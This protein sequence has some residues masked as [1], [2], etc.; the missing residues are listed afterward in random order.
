[1]LCLKNWNNPFRFVRD[2][3]L[4]NYVFWLFSS[5]YL[6]RAFDYNINVIISSFFGSA[7]I[8]T[9]MIKETKETRTTNRLANLAR[10]SI[11]QLQSLIQKGIV[12]STD[13][14][15][16]SY[17]LWAV[18]KRSVRKYRAKLPKKDTTNLMQRMDVATALGICIYRL[19]TFIREGILPPPTHLKPTGS[20]GYYHQDD[21]PKLKAKL[22][23]YWQQVTRNGQIATAGKVRRT[24]QGFYT[25]QSAAEEYLGIPLITFRSW[26][27]KGS[28]PKPTRS[29]DNFLVYNVQDLEAIRAIKRSYFDKRNR[30]NIA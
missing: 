9:P 15:R 18:A 17:D 8:D 19:H 11:E 22:Q 10:M 14:H 13:I 3:M 23:K 16:Y 30:R 4:L 28:I 6:F 27:T 5:H 25:C 26:L 12:P 2:V 24:R 21:L 29:V 20:K 7:S 1:M